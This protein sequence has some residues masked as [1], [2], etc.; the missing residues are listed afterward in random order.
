MALQTSFEDFHSSK[1]VC[2]ERFQ[3]PR[4]NQEET[5]QNF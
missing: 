1:S 5:G 3:E 4:G 2:G